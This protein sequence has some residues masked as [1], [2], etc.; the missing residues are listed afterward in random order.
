MRLDVSPGIEMQAALE[1]KA[2]ALAD[3]AATMKSFEGERAALEAGLA[4]AHEELHAQADQAASVIGKLTRDLSAADAL[5]QDRGAT[6]KSLQAE[7]D[8]SRAQ[9]L[10]LRVALEAAGRALK[11][12]RDSLDASNQLSGTRAEALNLQLR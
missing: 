2:A 9:I 6:N 11:E 10:D 12:A 7:L 3:M 4:E 8:A 1:V 5:A